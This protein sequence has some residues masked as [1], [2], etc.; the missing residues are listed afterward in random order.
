MCGRDQPAVSF[1]QF[2]FREKIPNTC[3]KSHL[4]H[5]FGLK[6]TVINFKRDT[7]DC[8]GRLRIHTIGIILTTNNTKHVCLHLT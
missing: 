3:L 2:M 7:S 6:F 8:E 5:D 4:R 1:K